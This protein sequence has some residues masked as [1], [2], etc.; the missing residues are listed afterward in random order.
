MFREAAQHVTAE[1][2]AELQ[3]LSDAMVI[4]KVMQRDESALAALYNCYS[5]VL[6]A[7]PN[8]ILRDTQAGEE[9]LQDILLQLWGSPSRFDSSSGSLP[10]WADHDRSESRHL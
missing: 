5:A 4:D 8:R 7:L 3:P 6:S 10:G 1:R 9:I 2:S